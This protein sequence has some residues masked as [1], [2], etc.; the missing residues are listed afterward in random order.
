[1]R[2]HGEK[3]DDGVNVE[4]NITFFGTK[5]W[6]CCLFNW[7]IKRHRCTIYWWIAE[8]LASPWTKD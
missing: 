7:R 8:L 1:M 5:I 4:K 2:F 3:M 6:L